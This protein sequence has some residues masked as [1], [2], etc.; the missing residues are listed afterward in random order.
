MDALEKTNVSIA[1]VGI[2]LGNYLTSERAC[3]SINVK[4]PLVCRY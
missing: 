2:G 4:V 1:I 3:G